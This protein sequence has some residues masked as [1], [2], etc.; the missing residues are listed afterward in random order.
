MQ[1]NH[2]HSWG[3]GFDVE[4]L[5]GIPPEEAGILSWVGVRR[6]LVSEDQ[7]GLQFD[8]G[9]QGKEHLGASALGQGGVALQEQQKAVGCEMRV[10]RFFCRQPRK[11]A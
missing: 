7:M 4:H 1:S 8:V 2:H 11:T 6:K 10:G 9:H 5:W 3:E